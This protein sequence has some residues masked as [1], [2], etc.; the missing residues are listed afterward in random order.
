MAMLNYT[1]RIESISTSTLVGTA[2]EDTEPIHPQYSCVTYISAI[3]SEKEMEFKHFP[4]EEG[5]PL[6]YTTTNKSAL[7]ILFWNKNYWELT[8]GA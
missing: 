7:L 6:K 3:G 4:D 2:T 1:H 5:K 8:A